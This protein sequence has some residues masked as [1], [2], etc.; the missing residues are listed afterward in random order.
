MKNDQIRDRGFSSDN[1]PT[2]I[3]KS[4]SSMKVSSPLLNSSI[5]MSMR[6]G[7]GLELSYSSSGE[8]RA[9]LEMSYAGS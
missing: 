7:A 6:V 5:P 8:S 9:D 2:D 1:V 4:Q 3:S